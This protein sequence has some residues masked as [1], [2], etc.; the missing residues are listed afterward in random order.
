MSEIDLIPG[1]IDP[2]EGSIRRIYVDDFL[3]EKHIYNGSSWT[4][5]C[6]SPKCTEEPYFNGLCKEHHEV[7]IKT[8]IEGEIRERNGRRYRW[9]INQWVPICSHNYCDEKLMRGTNYCKVHNNHM[10]NSHEIL[11][12]IYNMCEKEILIKLRK[13]NKNNDPGE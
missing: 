11:S 13:K 8:N 2:K 4:H 12:R 10:Y 9:M 6:R 3:S 7:Q 5:V 1:K